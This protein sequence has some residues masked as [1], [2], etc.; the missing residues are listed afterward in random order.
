MRRRCLRTAGTFHGV[1]RN[2]LQSH[3]DEFVY[4]HSRRHNLQAALQRLLGLGAQHVPTRL[5][6]VRGGITI[7]PSCGE[8]NGELIAFVSYPAP[9]QSVSE[10]HLT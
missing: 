4:R 8:G 1:G 2:Q 6:T 7:T 5:S 10:E 3:L 9:K